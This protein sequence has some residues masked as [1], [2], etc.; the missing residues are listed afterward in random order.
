MTFACKNALRLLAV[1]WLGLVAALPEPTAHLNPA[2]FHPGDIIE[3]DVLVI[4]GGSTGTY[5]AIRLRDLNQSVV[6]VETKNVLGGHTETYTDPATNATI[7]IGVI[8]FHNLDLVKRYFA[9]FD[10][11]LEALNLFD[12]PGV[13]KY[14]DF[15]TGDIVPG[16]TPPDFTQA[17]GV[18]AAQLAKYPYLESGFNL[19]DPVPADLLLSVGE[20]A[21]KYHLENLVYFLDIFSQGFGDLLHQPILY[22][23]RNLSLDVVRSIANGFLSTARHN[24]HELY[25]KALVELGAD[26]LLGSHVVAID[27]DP[28]GPHAKILVATRTGTKLVLAKKILITIPPTLQNLQHFDLDATERR[29]F[30]QFRSNSYYTAV[31]RNAGIPP[32]YAV[33]NAALDT[34]NHIPH[35]PGIYSLDRTGVPNL[36]NVKYGSATHIAPDIVKA[37]ILASIRRLRAAGVFDGPNTTAPSSSA[38]APDPEIAI[39]SDHTPF[40]LHVSAEAI[41]R[42]FYK[43]LYALQGCR[44]FWWTGAAWSTEDSSVLWEFTEGVLAKLVKA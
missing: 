10:V 24:N 16:F 17:L 37:D 2:D 20:F 38:N 44:R 6:V 19:P 8:V 14:A 35:F 32:T 42:G 28:A 21:T 30:E 11:P 13:S 29:L 39:F 25:D 9:R 18:Y 4:G 27:R 1:S 5:S 22:V 7:D 15:R 23:F 31:V 3:R 34:P 40:E 33:G 41:A 26:A 36:V 12:S 43:Q